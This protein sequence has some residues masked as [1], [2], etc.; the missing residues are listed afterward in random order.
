[1]CSLS[2]CNKLFCPQ[3]TLCGPGFEIKMIPTKRCCPV[4]KCGKSC[5]EGL[6][7]LVKRISDNRN[8]FHPHPFCRFFFVQCPK[9]SASTMEPSTRWDAAS[10]LFFF[11]LLSFYHLYIQWSLS[12]YEV[13]S[14]VRLLVYS[15]ARSLKK[16]RALTATVPNN[17]ILKQSITGFNVLPLPVHHV[18]WCVR[19]ISSDQLHSCYCREHCFVL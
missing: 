5:A 13:F 1:M 4:Y 19:E 3:P 18:L 10:Q 7:C 15:L 2:E 9:M 14:H 11:S 16:T 17:G 6:G 8:N 12:H